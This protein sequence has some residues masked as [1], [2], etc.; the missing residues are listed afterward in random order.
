MTIVNIC[1]FIWQITGIS[2]NGQSHQYF[3]LQER[4]GDY[5]PENIAIFNEDSVK[6]PLKTIIDKPTLFTFVYYRCP[7]LCPSLL[8]GVAELVNYSNSVP[9][10]DYQIITLSINHRESIKEARI[11][12]THYYK[13][14]QKETS[15]YFWRFFTADSTTV[16]NLTKAL[17]WGF[18]EEGE[19]NFVH[20][21][22]S[23]LIT[24]N[25]MISQYF[26][27]TYFNY[28]HFDMSVEKAKAEQVVP[29]RLKTLKYC[30]NYK[31]QKNEKVVISTVVFGVLVVVAILILFMS[32]SVFNKGKMY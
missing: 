20:V 19:G 3:G 26:Y 5:T 29:T 7:N 14:L 28:M 27:G 25:G 23:I 2:L 15:P 22:S 30:Y 31:P 24:P 12:K 11:K 6:V 16:K 4:Q 8:E 21:T 1:I 17:G 9:E 32:L 10:K 13:L 18:K